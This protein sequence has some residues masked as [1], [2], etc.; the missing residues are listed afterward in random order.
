M[1][2]LETWLERHSAATGER[3]VLQGATGQP[4]H[5]LEHVGIVSPL[6]LGALIDEADVI[7]THGGPGS[8][9]AVIA[10]GRQPIVIPRDPLLGEHVDAHQQRFATWLATKRPITVVSSLGELS[11]SVEEHRTATRA[12]HELVGPSDEVLDALRAIIQR[13]AHE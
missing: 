2:R 6:S 9:M 5:N 7:I 11:T 3:C 8:I 10:R 4:A 1:R 12:G 13:P